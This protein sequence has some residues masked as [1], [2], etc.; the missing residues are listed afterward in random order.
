MQKLWITVNDLLRLGEFEFASPEQQNQRRKDRMLINKRSRDEH[1]PKLW[2]IQDQQRRLRELHLS[3]KGPCHQESS[4]LETSIRDPASRQATTPCK[5]RH[6]QD[7]QRGITKA[8]AHLRTTLLQPK[9]CNRS[10]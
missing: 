7:Q 3:L 4:R 1:R 6:K 10:M 9:H 2:L 8:G 5:P